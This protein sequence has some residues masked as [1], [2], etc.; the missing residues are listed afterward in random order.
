MTIK[1]QY[2]DSF[3]DNV[4]PWETLTKEWITDAIPEFTEDFGGEYPF[5]NKDTAVEF[6]KFLEEAYPFDFRL[7]Y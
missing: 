4:G 1:I 3:G 6:L 2:Q 5:P 7:I